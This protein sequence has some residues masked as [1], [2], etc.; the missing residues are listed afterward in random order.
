[1]NGHDLLPWYVNGTLDLDEARSFEAHLTSCDSCRRELEVTRTV[2]ERLGPEGMA[3]L[4]EDHP[5]PPEILAAFSPSEA[6]VD[7]S[8]DRVETVHRHVS[9][10]AA[11]REESAWL[12][13]RSVARRR[14]PATGRIW[15]AATA[16]A[17]VLAIALGLLWRG[18]SVPAPD[19][20]SGL[21]R[22]VLVTAAQRDS[23][24]QIIEAPGAGAATLT[25]LFEVDVAQSDL[26]ATL[27][28]RTAD[29]RPIR[30]PQR[31][32]AEDLYRGAYVAFVCRPAD[33]VPDDYVAEIE[34]HGAARPPVTY[35]FRVK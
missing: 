6:D 34:L 24:D 26:P 17:V 11:C 13:G 30:A 28:V 27:T 32:A 16:A 20:G 1:M 29:G 8:A 23:G 25:L 4:L 15:W 19:V 9:V 12:Q 22:I 33:C 3:A 18:R 14:A 21:T 5:D 31:I 35:R 2:M 10:C 7:L